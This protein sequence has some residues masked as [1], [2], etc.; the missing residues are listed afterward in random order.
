MPQGNH[1]V[2]AGKDTDDCEVKL[3]LLPPFLAVTDNL[4]CGGYNVTFTGIYRKR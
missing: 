1:V 2:F 3:T 4:N